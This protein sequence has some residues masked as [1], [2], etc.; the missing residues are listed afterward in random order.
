MPSIYLAGSDSARL[1][2]REKE[3]ETERQKDI[4]RQ[5]ETEIETDRQTDRERPWREKMGRKCVL[6]LLNIFPHNCVCV[7]ILLYICFFLSYMRSRR[8]QCSGLT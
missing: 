8:R 7:L 5:T 1:R 2:V 4:E 6:I 3:G